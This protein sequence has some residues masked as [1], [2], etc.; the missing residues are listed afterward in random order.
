M[1]KPVSLESRESKP[2]PLLHNILP[3][4]TMPVAVGH[5]LVS[6]KDFLLFGHQQV[7]FRIEHHYQLNI[8]YAE[9]R[10]VKWVGLG[11]A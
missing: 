1:I 7:D 6:P 8:F 11:W 5:Y 10:G 2:N 3:S 9:I 4:T